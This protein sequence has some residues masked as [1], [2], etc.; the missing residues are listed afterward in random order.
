MKEEH[1]LEDG[2]EKKKNQDTFFFKWD[3]FLS[4]KCFSES[5]FVGYLH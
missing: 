4:K 1:T 2:E 3:F 5:N